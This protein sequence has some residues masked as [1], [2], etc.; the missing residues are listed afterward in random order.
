MS[1]SAASSRAIVDVNPLFKKYFNAGKI[2]V[3]KTGLS[4]QQ[5]EAKS[6]E[7]GAT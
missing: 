6:L 4:V 7:I 2:G 3:H 5:N 1:V